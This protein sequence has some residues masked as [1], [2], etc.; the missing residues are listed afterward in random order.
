MGDPAASD[1]QQGCFRKGGEVFDFAVAVGVSLVRRPRGHPH[2]QIGDAGGDQIKAA[3]QRLGKNAEAVGVE[4]GPEFQTGEQERPENRG[5]SGPAFFF[6]GVGRRVFDCGHG[7]F[8]FSGVG[9]AQDTRMTV[10]VKRRVN[11]RKP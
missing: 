7:S 6:F 1:K 3:V 2:S 9:R 11:E 4:A 8:P 5:Q 10:G